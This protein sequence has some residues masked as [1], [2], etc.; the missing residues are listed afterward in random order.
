MD[1]IFKE[2][3]KEDLVRICSQLNLKS[4]IL[5][6]ASSWA[7]KEDLMENKILSSK[8]ETKSLR[9]TL[10]KIILEEKF[11]KIFTVSYMN[12]V[13]SNLDEF[14]MEGGKTN[15]SI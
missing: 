5:S 3:M 1:K 9:K 4:N 7:E 8:K 12:Y 2:E 14:M 13:I 15:E 6:E 10:E 11:T